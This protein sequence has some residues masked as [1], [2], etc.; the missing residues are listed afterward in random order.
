MPSRLEP[1]DDLRRAPEGD[2]ELP[3][4]TGT[5]S[6]ENSGWSFTREADAATGFTEFVVR[7]AD[8]T[9]R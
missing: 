7:H 2:F 4:L 8:Q 9:N 3:T 5:V 6:E 1:G